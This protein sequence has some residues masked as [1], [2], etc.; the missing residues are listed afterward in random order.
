MNASFKKS[1]RFLLSPVLALGVGAFVAG[2][3]S[4]KLETA[5]DYQGHYLLV[6]KDGVAIQT[7]T[8]QEA[9]A[10]RSGALDTDR[11][12][13]SQSL[14]AQL[15]QTVRDRITAYVN[16]TG[17]RHEGKC[18][19]KLHLLII[20]HGGMNSYAISSKHLTGLMT[21]PV[22][23]P[24][25]P[26]GTY[27][28]PPGLLNDTCYYPLFI[29][30]D[31]DF[32]DSISDDLFRFR[33]G[34]RDKVL[35]WSTLPFV[36]V[37]RVLNSAMDIPVA[38]FHQAVTMKD[39]IIG[40]WQESDPPA[41][42]AGDTLI[43]LPAY[44]LSMA[45]LPFTQGFGAPAWGIMKRRV[46]EATGT[47]ATTV[48]TRPGGAART[49]IEALRKWIE[50]KKDAA[51][52]DQSYWRGTSTQVTVTLVG[53]SMG[54]LVINRL[55]QI[56]DDPSFPPGSPP[57]PVDRIIY[58]VPACSINEAEQ[59]LMPYLDRHPGT[60]FWLFTLNRRDESR[61][62]PLNGWAIFVPRGTLLTW[63][64]TFL[65]N[66]AGPGEGRFGWVK[67]LEEYYGLSAEAPK[68]R[69]FFEYLFLAEDPWRDLGVKWSLK[70]NPSR[71]HAY[72]SRR[73]VFDHSL[74]EYHS[75]FLEAEHFQKVLCKVVP[76]MFT[77]TETC[78]PKAGPLKKLPGN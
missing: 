29:N 28:D 69:G 11:I 30:W 8:R 50:V 5:Y 47:V 42:I 36:I 2:C 73:R 56:A 24:K 55:L 51:G 45:L 27:H 67:Y 19:G 9:D 38:L 14:E 66:E 72:A 76:A 63:I 70:T 58:L 39:G 15:E 37:S 4:F 21:P 54:A 65:E 25:K 49:L 59:L 3:A 41:G 22:S 20:V 18:A 48:K 61:E 34:E 10:N 6:H 62:I 53:H 35:V 75:D 23:L 52:Q 44:P 16:T 17:Q 12:L 31:S 68:A 77:S 7:P 43:N 33:F 60:H 26:V 78:E 40:A 74:P 64:D 57:L 71:L 32:G 13:F 46:D 1:S